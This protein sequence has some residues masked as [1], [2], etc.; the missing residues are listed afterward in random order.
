MVQLDEPAFVLDL[1]A[2]QLEIAELA[3]RTFRQK[4]PGLSIQVA[5]YFGELRENLVPFASLPVDTFHIDATRAP[6]DIAKITAAIR[7]GDIALSVGIIDGRNIWRTDLEKAF[8][9]VRRSVW[10]LGGERVLVAPSC[11]LLHVPVSVSRESSLDPEIASWLAFADE[12]L[13]EVSILRSL[14]LG[15]E[16]AKVELAKNRDLIQARR[17]SA[18]GHNLA[19]RDRVASLRGHM[20]KR[21]TPFSKRKEIQRAKLGLP[22]LPT[23]TIGSFPQTDEVRKARAMFRKGKLAEAEYENFLKHKTRDC[24]E[25]QEKA[26]LDVLV[27]GEFERTDMVEYFGEK[28]DGFAFTSFGW[29]QSY[30]SRCVKPP[31]IYGD[32]SRP[33]PM[34]VD[35]ARFAASCTA[36][37]MKGMLTG[38]V[39][40][41]QWSFVRDDQPRR[42][43]ATQIAMAL[44]DEVID[45]EAVGIPIIQIDEAAIREGVPLR[46]SDR[47]EYF[48]WAVSAFRLSA[49]G[50]SDE[51]QIHT[52]MCYSEFGDMLDAIIGMDADAITIENSR[53]NSELLGL[54][55]ERGYPNEIGPGVYD[56]HSPRIPSVDEMEKL[57]REMTHIFPLENLWV[58]PDCGLKTRKWEEVAPAL[59][60][61]TKAAE[62]VRDEILSES[63]TR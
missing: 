61:M 59:E 22:L 2:R 1:S 39:T 4:V 56:I 37:P 26:G 14:M 40:I 24:V 48:D 52:H 44:R 7:D 6:D 41:L 58:N 12:K 5:S 47:E 20:F 36:K 27:H 54:F 18:R 50:V 9:V 38:P 30:G 8:D 11:S 63:H 62:A 45:L 17:S 16:E 49:S 35:W 29:V 34:T 55:R 19:V 57:I 25:I 32:V 53:S 43:T 42:E 23:T 21:A 60:N 28:M 33:V 3:Y 15:E 46:N 13:D 10:E 31:V 51:T